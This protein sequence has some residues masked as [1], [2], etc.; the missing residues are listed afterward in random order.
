MTFSSIAKKQQQISSALPFL[1]TH[2]PLHILVLLLSESQS[3]SSIYS[4]AVLSEYE[5]HRPL[6]LN[7]AV[8][9][10]D[11]SSCASITDSGCSV[12][13]VMIYLSDS[14]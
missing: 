14:S 11:V 2:T 7:Q 9:K 3:R 1:T 6:S 10:M 8:H 5:K 12:D 13:Q 4:Q